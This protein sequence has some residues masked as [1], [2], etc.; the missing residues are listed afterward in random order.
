MNWRHNQG[1][2]R[3]NYVLDCG[4]FWI[5]YNPDPSL[6]GSDNGSD[7]TALVHDGRFYI[8]N[9][10]FRADYERLA[11]KGIQACLDFFRDKQEEF[12]SSWTTPSEQTNG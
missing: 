6:L 11:P 2:F 5:S 12:G 1:L 9:G 8:L 10:D 4:G 7:E 3:G